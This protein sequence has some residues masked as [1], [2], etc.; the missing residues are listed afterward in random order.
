M[1]IYAQVGFVTLVGLITKNGILIVE[2]A[3]K[4]QQEGASRRDAIHDAAMIRLRPVLMTSVA[5]IAGRFPL[6]LVT[7]A[8]AAARSS[9]GL[10]LVGGMA[11][12]TPFIVPSVHVVMAKDRHKDKSAAWPFRLPRL[13]RRANSPYA[14]SPAGG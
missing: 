2:F 1:D 14:I 12:G 8:G 9:I 4:L 7:S 13:M 11:N 10:V 6:V 3:N 5:T